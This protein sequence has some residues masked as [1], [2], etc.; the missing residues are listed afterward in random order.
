[1]VGLFPPTMHNHIGGRLEFELVLCLALA[2][3]LGFNLR[4][5][6]TQKFS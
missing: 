4:N 6:M 3:Q 2:L 1:M 5:A